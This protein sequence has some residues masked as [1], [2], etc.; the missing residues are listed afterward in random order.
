M[1]CSVRFVWAVVAFVIAA[2]MIGAG[3][4]Q[5]TVF[6][7]PSEASQTVETD[8]STAYTLVDG[9]VLGALPG[10]QTLRIE[11]DGQVFAAYGR[12]DD[13]RAWLADT[14]YTAVTLDG[15]GRAQ[16]STVEPTVEDTSE[17]STSG[18]AAAPRTPVGSDLW[19][20][21]FQQDGSLATTLQLPSTMSVL[22]ASDGVA[23]A[24][25][26]ISVTWPTDNSTPWAGPLI[27]GG[28]IA[29][30]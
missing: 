13:V 24:P 14:E 19:L 15:E 30:L 7:G 28:S 21:E 17:A 29:L 20:D 11:G 12:T 26:E 10:A 8:A 5:R 2:V 18:E 4:A 25:S 16:T 9:T 1:V 27:V 6:Q 3:I 23:P 22:V